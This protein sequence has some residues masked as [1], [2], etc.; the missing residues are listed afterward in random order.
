MMKTLAVAEEVLRVLKKSG[1]DFD[2]RKAAL[3]SSSALHEADGREPTVLIPVE[4]PQEDA[5]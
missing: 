3:E 5:P 4:I 1:L 2:H